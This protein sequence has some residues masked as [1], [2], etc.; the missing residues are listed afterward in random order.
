MVVPGGGGEC[1]TL[2]LL[3]SRTT[4]LLTH[5][6]RPS[7]SRYGIPGISHCNS[8]IPQTLSRFASASVINSLPP[9]PP[10]P[11]PYLCGSGGTHPISK[12]SD[13]SSHFTGGVVDLVCGGGRWHQQRFRTLESALSVNYPCLGSLSMPPPPPP[14]PPPRLV[15]PPLFSICAR[16]QCLRGMYIK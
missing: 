9:P 14:L 13:R 5:N 15:V 10:P 6:P 4:G 1:V 8:V 2:P 16:T 3:I 11:L 12:G 7:S